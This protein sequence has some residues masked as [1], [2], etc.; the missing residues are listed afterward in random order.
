MLLTHLCIFLLFSYIVNYI[1]YLCYIYY[2]I[3][4]IVNIKVKY[5][6]KNENVNVIVFL[7]DIPI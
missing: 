4:E 3:Y 7:I 6:R 5:L 2:I 1:K